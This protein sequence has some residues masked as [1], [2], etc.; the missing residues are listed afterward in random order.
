VVPVCHRRTPAIGY[1]SEARLLAIIGSP[2]PMT[3]GGFDR[4]DH[5]GHLFHHFIHGV[6]GWLAD[7][8]VEGFCGQNEAYRLMNG[9]ARGQGVVHGSGENLELRLLSIA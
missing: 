2:W 3:R 5:L 7:N 6:H 1:F 4:G 9:Q 8:D